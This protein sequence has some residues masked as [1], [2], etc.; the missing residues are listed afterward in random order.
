MDAGRQELR[1]AGYRARDGLRSYLQAISG[2]EAKPIT[3]DDVVADLISP[4]GKRLLT[5]DLQGKFWLYPL[6]GGTPRE[7]PQSPGRSRNSVAVVIGR[8]VLVRGPGELS[9]NT[10]Q[11]DVESGAQNPVETI[12]AQGR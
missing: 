2:G 9:V 6:Q 10:Y 12:H 4:D 11:V 8:T 3:P 5:Y 7:V 1:C